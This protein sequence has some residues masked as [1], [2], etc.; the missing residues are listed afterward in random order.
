MFKRLD[1]VIIGAL[2]V[3]SF[4]PEII[5]GASIGRGS[6][7]TYAE[8]MVDGEIYKTINLSQHKGEEIFEINSENG[9][10]VIKVHNDEI[11]IIDADCSDQVCMNPEHIE[12]S[13][14]SLVCL[15]N[16]VIVLIKGIDVDDTILSY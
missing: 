6:K 13:G 9:L 16:K 10:N 4:L 8:I 7:E 3:L 14:E 15:P 5:L 1:F 12:K 2:L 11:G